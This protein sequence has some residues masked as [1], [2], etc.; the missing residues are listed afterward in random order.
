MNPVRDVPV[1]PDAPGAGPSS[2]RGRNVLLAVALVAGTFAGVVAGAPVA[3]ARVATI[4]AVALG[5]EHSCALTATGGVRCWG[6]NDLGQIGDGT[7]VDRTT[8][9]DVAGLTSGVVAISA[10]GN[11]ACALTSAGG[12]KCWGGNGFGGIGDGTTTDRRTPVDVV[13]LTSGVVAIGVGAFH[14]C[15]VTAGGGLKCWGNNEYGGLG[16][17]TLVTRLTPVD[18]VGLS[19]G[20]VAVAAGGRQTCALTS[21]GGLKCWGHNQWGQ[22]GDGTTTDRSTPVDVRGLPSGVTAVTAGGRHTC[23][24]TSAGGVKCWGRNDFGQVGDGGAGDPTAPVDVAGLTSGVRMVSAG[25]FHTCA[26]M[27]AGGVKCWGPPDGTGDVGDSKIPTPQDMAGLSSG[28]V[29]LSA[30]EGHT[31]VLMS[32]GGV[33]CFGNNGYGELGNGT[34]VGTMTPVNVIGAQ[35]AVG[36]LTSLFSSVNPSGVGQA[37]TFTASVRLTS[38]SGAPAGTISFVEGSVTLGTSPL[39]GGS[40]SF[41]TSALGV[42]SHAITAVYSG[43]ATFAGST[44]PA[45]TQTVR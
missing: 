32:T 3:D 36:T 28:A 8:A 31:C 26:V 6:L 30:G 42:G 38:R 33:K 15:A 13:G 11:H 7:N 1:R 44:S 35:A 14:S 18:V 22:V 40:A 24:R 9:V 39:F 4:T 23:A 5:W 20:V 45:L 21:V 25:R 16:D 17:G 27:S 34:T 37:V 41:T 12:V 43:D 10:G 2:A 29:A 19:S